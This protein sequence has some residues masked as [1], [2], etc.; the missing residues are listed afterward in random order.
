MKENEHS[1]LYYIAVIY[2]SVNFIY[3]VSFINLTI[4]LLFG[5]PV[6][7]FVPVVVSTA[8]LVE[9][10]MYHLLSKHKC[11]IDELLDKFDRR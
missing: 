5:F 10:Y 1:I 3:I 11:D 4:S 7:A 8:F 6:S 9:T 2:L